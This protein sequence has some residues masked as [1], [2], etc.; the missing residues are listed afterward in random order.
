MVS[1][2]APRF[3]NVLFL[4]GLSER[5]RHF[6]LKC[7]AGLCSKLVFA[8]LVTS[9]SSASRPSPLG[10][11]GCLCIASTAHTFIYRLIYSRTRAYQT[12]SLSRPLLA[13][14]LLR[15][16]F[17]FPGGT[18]RTAHQCRHVGHTTPV[19]LSSTSSCREL[20][21]THTSLGSPFQLLL[22]RTLHQFLRSPRT[23]AG[24]CSTSYGQQGLTSMKALVSRW[25]RCRW[26]QS[27]QAE[28][29]PPTR[30]RLG[31]RWTTS[32]DQGSVPL[33]MGH[34]LGR[35]VRT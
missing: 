2:K 27:C 22:W 18:S 11:G 6:K 34:W 14:G 3:D 20:L 25:Q 23:S 16:A 29:W 9:I 4:Q 33:G 21:L 8:T 26:Q 28:A 5:V 19:R 30:S 15:I 1:L 12:L 13:C 32:S 35:K 17:D 10:L 24:A 7:V 31:S